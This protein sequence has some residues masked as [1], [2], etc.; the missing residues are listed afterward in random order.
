MLINMSANLFI[1]TTE[2]SDSSDDQDDNDNDEDSNDDD[3]DDDDD[4]GGDGGNEG[5]ASK[6]IPKGNTK[7][8]IANSRY[9][10]SASSKMSIIFI[11]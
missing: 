6:V 10:R 9:R 2:V 3:D 7:T 5:K 11:R 4:N 8:K 1:T